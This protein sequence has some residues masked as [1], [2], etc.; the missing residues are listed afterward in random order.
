MTQ[1]KTGIFYDLTNIIFISAISLTVKNI[2]V[3]IIFTEDN[4]IS[5]R[6]NDSYKRKERARNALAVIS[7]KFCLFF[8]FDILTLSLM[9]VYLA[10]FFTIFK[11]TLFFVL[12]NSLI[13][14]GVCMVVP[15]FLGLIPAILRWFSLLTKESQSRIA[16]YYISKIFHIFT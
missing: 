14:F 4:I 7:V 8:V 13:S 12:K 11:N 9:W 10:C 2:L 5:I 15:F 16:A 3:Q 6:E 1:G